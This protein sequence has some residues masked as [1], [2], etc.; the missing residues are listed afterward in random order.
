MK[1]AIIFERAGE[2]QKKVVDV[3]EDYDH[4]EINRREDENPDQSAMLY[5]GSESPLQKGDVV[6]LDWDSFED[7][8]DP[9]TW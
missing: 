9:E 4:Q 8:S 2:N 6:A 1:Y 7:Y 5:S 3:V